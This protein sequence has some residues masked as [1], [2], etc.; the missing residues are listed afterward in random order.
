M[1]NYVNL[2]QLIRK[3]TFGRRSAE[4]IEDTHGASLTCPNTRSRRNVAQLL[5]GIEA[6]Q[7]IVQAAHK[8][9]LVLILQRRHPS[10][11]SR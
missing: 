4:E 6:I 3:S 5:R 7:M 9:R 8:M 1:C 11:L 2:L 10:P